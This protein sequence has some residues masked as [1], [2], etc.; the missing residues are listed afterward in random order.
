M[1]LPGELNDYRNSR[2]FF[3]SVSCLQIL[4]GRKP[5]TLV[6]LLSQRGFSQNYDF[7]ERSE[8]NVSHR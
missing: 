7:S 2:T 3:M 1:L 8:N 5:T 4:I 6:N